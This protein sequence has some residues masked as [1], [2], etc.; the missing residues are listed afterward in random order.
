MLACLLGV[1]ICAMVLVAA[2]VLTYDILSHIFKR[3]SRATRDLGQAAC[4]KASQCASSLCW[5]PYFLHT[6][7]GAQSIRAHNYE[8]S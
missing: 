8:H 5:V 4:A 7:E 6:F 2:A 1:T 3:G